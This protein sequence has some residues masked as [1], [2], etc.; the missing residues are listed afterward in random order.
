MQGIVFKDRH[1]AGGRLAE[2]LSNL[3]GRDD[4]VVL[5]L[6]RGGLPVAYE[7]ARALDAPLDLFLVRKLGVPGQPE[8]AMGAIAMGGVQ[9]MNND[10]IKMLNLRPADIEQVAAREGEE[11]ER[12]N[13]IYRGDRPLPELRNKIVLLVDDGLATG[14]T[15]RAAVTGLRSFQPAKI[16]V[17]VPT[18]APEVCA[19][20]E[21]EADQVVCLS[22]PQPFEAVG[23]WYRD[24][25]QTSDQEVCE[26][27]AR[28]RQRRGEA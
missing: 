21:V 28:D 27:L 1:D 18:G 23:A 3:E 11:M 20:L 10:V 24:F 2:K 6:P 12:R 7:V 9:V 8:F 26:L 15:M 14:A 22:T 13:R 5:G 16:I 25:S 4:V 19:R 17:A